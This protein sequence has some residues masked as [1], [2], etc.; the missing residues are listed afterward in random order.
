M[1]L[2]QDEAPGDFLASEE[3]NPQLATARPLDLRVEAPDQERPRPAA[4]MGRA[5]EGL[6]A[7]P[8]P[9]PI[10]EEELPA[11]AAP[12]IEETRWEVD[13]KTG[14]RVHLGPIEL[15]FEGR[16]GQGGGH[17]R[18]LT[19]LLA[20]AG[21]VGMVVVAAIA[22]GRHRGPAPSAHREEPPTRD[23]AAPVPPGPAKGRAE[24][25]LHAQE[26]GARAAG[27]GEPVAEPHVTTSAPTPLAA[28][29]ATRGPKPPVPEAPT[30]EA[31]R[32]IPPPRAA[33]ASAAMPRGSVSPFPDAARYVAALRRFDA[34]DPA[35]AALLFQDLAGA[36]DPGRFTLQLMIA[37]ENE[38]L[39]N[40][41]ARSGDRGSLYFLP[42]TL[43][44]RGCF[45]VCWGI[46]EHKETAG[47]AIGG[48]TP[49]LAA[50]GIKP[51][52][53]S[54]ARLKPRAS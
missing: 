12:P 6:P 42:F 40:L 20:G 10:P 36:E 38:T 29:P 24:A 35:G 46:Y 53:L 37:C 48:L 21:A 47:S 11:F 51:I 18:L 16:V 44:D 28:K 26:P 7:E 2:E 34:G 31:P 19:R 49:S 9:P 3:S 17:R 43:K 25:E 32:L 14:E 27:T 5:A 50:E 1:H 52:V 13:P 39:Q 8:D 45:R 15:T 30:S 4:A 41:R 54:L 23:A 22:L 33:E